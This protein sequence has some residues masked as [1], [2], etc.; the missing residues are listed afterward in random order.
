MFG[1]LLKYEFKSL[2]KWYLSLYAIVAVLSIVLGFWI[3]FLVARQE[4]STVLP[5][6]EG[7]LFGIL[8]FAFA[9]LIGGLMISTF[10]LVVRRFYTNVYDRQGYL[11][12]TLPVTSH[13]IILSKLLAAF[14]WYTLAG[15]MVLIAAL[16]IGSLAIP[17][18]ILPDLMKEIQS[19]LATSDFSILLQILFGGLVSSISGILLTYLAISLGQLFKDHRILMAVVFYFGISFAIG[20]FETI[21]QISTASY[22]MSSYNYNPFPFTIVLHLILIPIFYFGTHYIMAKKLNLQ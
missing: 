5:E 9:L 2:G 20:V 15:L 21:F 17:S 10:L 7:W 4:A 19:A 6:A 3:R 1:K 18:Y 22:A 11:T 16:I 8:I 12:M 13:Q 14:I